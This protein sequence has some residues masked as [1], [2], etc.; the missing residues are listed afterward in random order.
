MRNYTLAAVAALALAVPATVQA[1]ARTGVIVVDTDQIMSS[2]TA[3]RSA[4]QQLQQRENALRSRAQTLQQQLQTEGKP[5]QDALDALKGK[6]PDAALQQ[7][8]AA[9]QTKQQNAQQEL[10]NS[11]RQLQSTAAHVQQQ[12]GSRLVQIVEQVRARRGAAI[13]IAKD[14][15]LANDNSVDVTTEVLTSL[16]SALPS[17]SVT[18]LPQQQQQRPQGR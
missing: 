8:V 15:T 1:Q 5:I 6:Q 18:P 16:N 7:R 14:S 17:V 9:F 11:Q 10:A 12:I 4:S 13:A 2:C 3:C